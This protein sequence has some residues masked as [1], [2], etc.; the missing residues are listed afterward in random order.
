MENHHLNSELVHLWIW[1]LSQ[2]SLKYLN[3]H[4]WS[5]ANTLVQLEGLQ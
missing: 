2:C 3:S 4:S 1:S 5:K